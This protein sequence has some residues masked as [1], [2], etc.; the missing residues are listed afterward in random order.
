[1]SDNPW[2]E[3]FGN[4]CPLET[5]TVIDVKR[6]CGAVDSGLAAGVPTNNWRDA[7]HRFWVTSDNH[8]NDIIAYRV[9]SS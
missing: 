9:V 1:M 8:A 2:I 5:G 3:W 4:R 6:R 7:D